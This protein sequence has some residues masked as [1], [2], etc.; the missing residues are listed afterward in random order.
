MIRSVVRLR[1]VLHTAFVV[2]CAASGLQSAAL[3]DGPA[4]PNIV[5]ILADDVGTEVLGSYGG[6]SYATPR[7]DQ[8]AETGLRFR[9]AYSMP[10][11]HP[12]RICLL[13]GRYPFRHNHPDWGS[14]PESAAANTVAARLRAAGYATA[15]AGKWQ[16]TLLRDDLDHPHRLG[17][18]EYCLFGWHEGPRYH[19]PFIWQNGTRRTDVDQRFGPEVYVDFL[20]DFIRR[21]RAEP[22]FAYYSM[23]LC[24]D[25]SDDLPDPPPVGPLGRWET[26]AEMVAAMDHQVGRLL[27]ALENLGVAEN[28]AVFFL[29]DN[30][31]P[32][33]QIVDFRDGEYV[34]RPIFSRR[35]DREI[36]GGKTTLTDAG[37]HVPLIVRWPNRV[38][39]G[40]A[41]DALV[42]VSDVSPTLS[43]LAAVPLPAD[44]SL[45]GISF[46]PA[47]SDPDASPRE[48]AFAEIGK[49]NRNDYW[50]RTARYKL[51]RSGR[52]FDVVADPL[53]RRPLT[54]NES[55]AQA[56]TRAR[57]Q[58]ALDALDI[59]NP[60]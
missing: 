49:P 16:L 14:F 27:D 34:R 13:T 24:H 1:L 40:R 17:F 60:R 50:V 56:S 9:H 51:Y 45:D 10:S 30:G 32:I 46:V 19:R 28:T 22:F 41:S 38:Q 31:T 33:R 20:V 58:N 18:D 29:G 11:C 47:F 48:V 2:T 52:L 15:V 55:A 43:E 25:V 8:L 42:D 36:A 35:G 21:H 54:S 3:A 6:T 7:L 57:L 53:E 39:G 26:F 59:S 23:A 44:A 4:R 12:T 5:L 37:T